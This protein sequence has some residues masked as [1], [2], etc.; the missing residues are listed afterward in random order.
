M[1]VRRNGLSLLQPCNGWQDAIP[2]VQ[3][4]DGLLIQE[5]HEKGEV[6][7]AGQHDKIALIVEGADIYNDMASTIYG[8]PVDRK[9]PAMALEGTLGKSAVL[10]CGFQMGW[11]RFM[12]Q[13]KTQTGLVITAEQA[14]S[15]VTTYRQEFAP[16]VPHLWYGLQDAS[17]QAVWDRRP[18]E[19]F[20]IEYKIENQWL[21]ARL[22]SGR[23]LH[24]FDPRPVKKPMPWDPND[25]RKGWTY[26]TMKTGQWIKRHAYG[27][28]LTENVVQGTARDIMVDRMFAV[29]WDLHYP[30]ILTVHD[31]LVTEPEIEI[32]SWEAMEECMNDAPAWARERGIPVASEC[33][34]GDRYK[35]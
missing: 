30:I 12:A 7:L 17:T 13:V 11:K 16:K 31:E 29:E 34:L 2:A 35:K 9:D 4:L 27:G 25:I 26:R 15:A 33:W 20:G 18:V 10:G 24:Y 21:T 28:L 8:Y 3:E 14:Q 19:A 5:V 32:A 1:I 23:K 22:P 6:A